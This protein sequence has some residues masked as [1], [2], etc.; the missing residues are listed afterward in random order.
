MKTKALIATVAMAA[1]L[2]ALPASAGTLENMERERSMLISTILNPDLGPEK[3]QEKISVAKHRLVDLERMVLRDEG[4]RGDTSPVV[5]RA[6]ADYDLT[7]L[8]HAS[9]E[10]GTTV[11]DQ[12]LSRL[13]LT[14][15]AIKN[16]DVGRR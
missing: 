5:R 16:A 9:V 3:R 12:W 4:L 8:V 1:S 13:G 10:S 15:S 2:T 6:F 14:T 7:F 11:A